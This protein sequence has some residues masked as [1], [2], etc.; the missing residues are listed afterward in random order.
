MKRFPILPTLMTLGNLFFGFLAIGYV[1]KAQTEAA[2]FGQHMHFAGWMI[3]VA[4]VFDA[5]DGKVARLYRVTSD[6]GAELDSLCDM[7]SFGVAPGLMIKALADHQNYMEKLGWAAGVFFVVCVAL[8]LARFNVETD[9]SEDSHQYFSGL[10]SP[11]GAGFVAAIMIMYGKLQVDPPLEFAGL[12]RAL[13]PVMDHLLLVMPVAGVALGVLMISNVRYPHMIGRLTRS[14]EP[15]PYVMT[16]VCV[17]IVVVLTKPFSFPVLLGAY[18]L[19]GLVGWLRGQVKRMTS[20]DN[21][22]KSSE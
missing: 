14:R 1:L 16:L 7:V 17:V 20:R 15:L 11:A 4:M 10:P 22:T 6:F 3:F 13:S 9:E 8:R 21:G 12:A 5:L 18:V 2:E 19:V